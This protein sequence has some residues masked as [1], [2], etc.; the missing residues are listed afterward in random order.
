M[1]AN[2]AA[3][4]SPYSDKGK[5]GLPEFF[6]PPDELDR[7]VA[8]L[9]LLIQDASN[10]VFHTGAGISTS[11]GIPD[12]RGPN[13][14]WTMEERGLSPKFDTTFENARPSTTH[15]ALLGLQRAGVL[16]FLVSQNVDG[17]H[18]RSGFP[19]DKLAELHGNMFVE[20]CMKCGKQYVRDAV[21]GT[22]GLKPT[23]RLCDVSKR[24]GLRSCRGKLMDTILDWEDSLPDRDLNL[25]SEASRSADLSITLGTSLQIKPSGDLPLLTKKKGGKLVIVNLQPTKHDKHADLR[26]H[27]YVD[28]VMAKLMKHLGLEIPEWTRPLVVEKAE[29]AES[30]AFAKPGTDFKFLTKAEPLG[31]NPE[32]GASPKQEPCATPDSDRVVPKRLKLEPLPT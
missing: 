14:V 24:R 26:I 20:E 23:G 12:F 29:L 9:A 16:R 28:D 11:S 3:G 5:C 2:Y 27:G 8:Q 13:G 4:L 1:S 18:V 22:M 25:A 19:R 17:L 15:M 30:K 6:D 21:V 32:D 10:V 7:K 31:E